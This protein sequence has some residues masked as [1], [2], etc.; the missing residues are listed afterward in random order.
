MSETN[1]REPEPKPVT[2]DDG[3]PLSSDKGQTLKITSGGE[4]EDDSFWSMFPFNRNIVEP[5]GWLI[6]VAFVLGVV[7][8]LIYGLRFTIIIGG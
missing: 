5:I 3:D 2:E 4:E 1:A 6:K 7:I 8:F